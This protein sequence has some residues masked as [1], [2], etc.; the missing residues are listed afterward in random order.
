MKTKALKKINLLAH[1]ISPPIP[2]LCHVIVVIITGCPIKNFSIGSGK[3][4]V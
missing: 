3:I 2:G 4:M 1:I